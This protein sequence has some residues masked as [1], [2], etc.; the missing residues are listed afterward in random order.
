MSIRPVTCPGC[1]TT[2]NVPAAMAN[3]KCPQ[4]QTIWNVG[5]PAAA[6]LGAGAIAAK[7][8]VA[9]QKQANEK[10]QSQMPL[11]ATL[12][13]AA[14]V[15]LAVIGITVVMLS[16]TPAPSEVVSNEVEETIK[17]R[18]PQPY[19]VVDLPEEQ[20]R[21]I[22][23][24]YRKVARTT[25]EAPLMVPQGNV[26]ASLENMLEKTYDRELVT[27]AALHD[28]KVEDVFEII[29]EGDAKVWDNSPRSHA[30][31][32]GKRVYAEEMSEG[33]KKPGSNP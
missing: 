2:L 32:D 5:N 27:F 3:V 7:R 1:G 21:R 20:R 28:I 19:V 4:C 10:S 15:L 26:R 12:V 16:S 11:I 22:Y 6:Q 23:D 29:K 8:S 31:R 30:T 25:V 17:P 14:M 18:T 9:D 33:W 24:D 13:A